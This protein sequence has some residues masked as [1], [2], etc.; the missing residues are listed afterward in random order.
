MK[1]VAELIMNDYYYP[2]CKECEHLYSCFSR[3]EIQ[4]IEEDNIENMYL[5]PG[6]CLSFYPEV[7]Q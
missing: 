5:M 1:K 6:T 3:D 2:L 7:R 4:D